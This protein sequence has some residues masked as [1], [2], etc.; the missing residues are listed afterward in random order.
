LPPGLR[1]RVSGLSTSQL[2]ALRFASDEELPDLTK[3]VLDGELRSRGDI[4]RA[5]RSWRA[6]DLRA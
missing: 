4:K 6:D 2:I 3:R 1:D 5:I